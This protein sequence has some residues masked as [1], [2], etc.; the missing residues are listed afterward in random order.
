MAS[1]VLFDPA[2]A[3]TGT[4]PAASSMQTSTTRLC[5]AW[6]SVGD[7]PVVPTGTRPF[8]PS[9]I[10]QETKLRKAFS[11]NAPSS[12]NGVTSAVIEPFSMGKLQNNKHCPLSATGK[13]VAHHSRT[14]LMAQV[15]LR[16]VNDQ[17]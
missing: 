11:S 7:S 13:K 8:V 14:S 6:E 15:H 3:I 9:S 17:P 4:F 16:Y 10:C 5:S 2:P 1:R 12:R